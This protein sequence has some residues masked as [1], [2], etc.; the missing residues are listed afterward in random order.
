MFAFLNNFYMR[1]V[2]SVMLDTLSHKKCCCE[3]PPPQHSTQPWT[4]K[5]SCAVFNEATNRDK[6][7]G[8]YRLTQAA[9]TC[10]VIQLLIIFTMQQWLT[11][12]KPMSPACSRKHLLHRLRPYLRMSPWVFLQRRLT[13]KKECILTD[14]C[15][16]QN[17]MICLHQDIITGPRVLCLQ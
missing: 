9:V 14:L 5:P 11:F 4:E 2:T 16:G 6:E 15:F 10:N 7:K 13:G 1:Y 3:N 17:Q 8:L 12:R